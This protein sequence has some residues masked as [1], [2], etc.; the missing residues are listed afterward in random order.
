MVQKESL[1][2]IGRVV[3]TQGNKGEV[4]VIPLTDFPD[5]FQNLKKIYLVQKGKEPITIEIEKAWYHKGFVILKIK[6]YDNISQAEELK[7]SL[8]AIPEEERIKLKRSEY[9]IDNLIGLEVETKK[10]EK[11]GKVVEVIKNPG[12]DIYVVRNGKELWIPAIKE[13]VK[14]IDLKNKKMIIHMIEGLESL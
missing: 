14:K 12:N 2:N 13:V 9:Y 1:V 10:G 7:D 6:G 3:T 5:R 4:R 8:T 11:L